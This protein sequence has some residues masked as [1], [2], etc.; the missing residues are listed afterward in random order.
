MKRPAL[1]VVLLSLSILA[2]RVSIDAFDPPPLATP[3]PNLAASATPNIL[4]P[5][6]TPVIVLPPATLTPS[7]ATL[8]PIVDTPALTV[9]QLKNGQFNLP[10][11]DGAFYQVEFEDGFFQQGSDPAEPGYAAIVMTDSIAFG[12]LDGD[13]AADAA[14]VIVENYGGTGQFVS[15]AA[16]LNQ[17][18]MPVYA[19]SHFVDDRALVNA[20]AIYNGEIYLDAVVHAFEDPGCCPTFWTRRTLRL[21]ENTLALAGFS[22]QTPSG[23]ERVINIESPANGA[24]VDKVFT[25][26]GSISIAPFENN[27]KYEVY[28]PSMSAAFT[29]GPLMVNAPDL[30]APGTFELPLNFSAAGYTGPVRISISDISAAD[31]SLLAMDVLF[32]W[33]K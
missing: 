10:G 8:T 5:T 7:P 2:C 9:E 24:E 15:V 6:F 11:A 14:A 20:F 12:D 22:S 27:L 26:R 4:Q 30:G 32:V 33:V 28:I 1:L 25:L 29:Q 3:I 21:W 18:G 13:G 17:G 31:G 23:A 19:A 16:F